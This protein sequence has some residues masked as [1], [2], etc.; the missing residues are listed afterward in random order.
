[1]I[2]VEPMGHWGCRMVADTTG[3]LHKMADQVG[4]PRRTMRRAPHPM[5]NLT[6][7]QRQRAVQLGVTELDQRAFT[8]KLRALQAAEE[9]PSKERGWGR[10]PR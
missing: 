3:E 9:D 10:A 6:W 4:V 2:Y 5:Y 7:Q 1:M 8:Q